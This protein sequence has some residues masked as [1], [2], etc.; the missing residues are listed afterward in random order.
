[1][2]QKKQKI[3]TLFMSI[4]DAA[5]FTGL[6]RHYLRKGVRNNEIPHICCGTT[7]KVNVPKLLDQM[8][9]PYEPIKL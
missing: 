9:V 7:Y 6:S 2:D 3:S 8:G 5:T 4:E 1:M